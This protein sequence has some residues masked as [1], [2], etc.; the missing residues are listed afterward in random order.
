MAEQT[1]SS[2]ITS[3]HTRTVRGTLVG[4]STSFR[5]ASVIVF[6]ELTCLFRDIFLDSLSQGELWMF[7]EQRIMLTLYMLKS[8]KLQSQQLL[9][10]C[11]HFLRANRILKKEGSQEINTLTIAKKKRLSHII[12]NIIYNEFH[13][14]FKMMI[15]KF[16]LCL[17]S[18]Q[19]L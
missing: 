11:K 14:C 2:D 18:K 19:V 12:H 7:S 6:E 16:I 1:N 8:H 5:I 15:G 4:C 3:L 10:K 13:S 9:T 17:K